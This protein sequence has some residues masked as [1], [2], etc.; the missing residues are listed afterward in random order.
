M[1]TKLQEQLMELLGTRKGL[2]L[3]SAMPAGGLRS[4]MDVALHAC[5]RF[6]REFVAVEEEEHRYQAVENIPVTTYNAADGQSPADVLP[7]SSAPSR[8]WWSSATWS[9]PRR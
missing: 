8:T 3:F 2:V 1:R 7:S 6:T 4:T 5:D 9:T